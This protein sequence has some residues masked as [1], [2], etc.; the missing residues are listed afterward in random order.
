M[1]E[2]TPLRRPR[3]GTL[4][5]PR[6]VMPSES[7]SPTTADTLVVPMSSPTTMSAL[8]I[9]PFMTLLVAIARDGPQVPRALRAGQVSAPRKPLFSS[10][11]S[12]P[13]D[14]A[15]GVRVV[16]EKHHGGLRAAGGD[17]GEH[18]RRLLDGLPVGP[19]AHAERDGVFADDE[20]QPA[21]VLH[22]DL[23]EREP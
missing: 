22:M 20:H 17:L 7:T 3:Q 15:L 4:P 6:M 16:I 10:L 1:F 11:S 9:R 12:H 14:H 23:L 8:S 18:P 21:V 19:L 5:T 2:T 13:H